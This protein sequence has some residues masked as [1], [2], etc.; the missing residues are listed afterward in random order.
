MAHGTFGLGARRYSALRTIRTL[1]VSYAANKTNR[2]AQLHCFAG[3]AFYSC[4]VEPILSIDDSKGLFWKK[5]E[6]MAF[7]ALIVDLFAEVSLFLF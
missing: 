3:S 2:A 1:F 6:T 4:I 5:G 7:V